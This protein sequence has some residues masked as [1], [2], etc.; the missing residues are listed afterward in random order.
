MYNLFFMILY[1]LNLLPG[2]IAMKSHILYIFT[3]ALCFTHIIV[4]FSLQIIIRVINMEYVILTIN[5]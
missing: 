2:E 3:G 5:K 4:I 1:E